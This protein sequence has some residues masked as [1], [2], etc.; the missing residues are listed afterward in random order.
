MFLPS[1]MAWRAAAYVA[2]LVC[3]TVYAVQKAH[4][5]FIQEAPAESASRP[6]SQG[7]PSGWVSSQDPVMSLFDDTYLFSSPQKTEA[8]KPEE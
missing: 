8:R 7:V 5:R 4:I 2:V 6:A 3:P 1:T